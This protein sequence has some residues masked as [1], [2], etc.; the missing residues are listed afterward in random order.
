VE[1]GLNGVREIEIAVV[2][3]TTLTAWHAQER[4]TDHP[5]FHGNGGNAANRAPAARLRRFLSQQRRLWRI[6]R[7]ACGERQCRRRIRGLRSP[8]RTRYAGRQDRGLRRVA[9]LWS[10]GALGAARQARPSAPGSPTSSDF[11]DME[12][13]ISR[14]LVYTNRTRLPKLVGAISPAQEANP[15]CSTSGCGEHVPDAVSDDHCCFNRSS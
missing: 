14:I 3:G 13:Q 1:V 9:R 12:Q 15:E 10:G 8:D 11:I 7:T 4:Q 5:Y 2:D 6:R